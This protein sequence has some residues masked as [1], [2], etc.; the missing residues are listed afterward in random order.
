MLQV[1]ICYGDELEDLLK[2]VDKFLYD[3]NKNR[4]QSFIYYTVKKNRVLRNT[5]G[6][7]RI[8]VI[9]NFF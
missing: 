6:A 5:P 2:V 4:F 1:R 7:F 3:V 9:K 8:P